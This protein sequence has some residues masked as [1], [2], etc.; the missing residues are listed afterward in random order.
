[1]PRVADI[2]ADSSSQNR[3][4]RASS[5]P[6]PMPIV[7]PVNV[8][9]I[10]WVN[11]VMLVGKVAQKP[12]LRKIPGN[13][14]LAEFTLDVIRKV[15]RKNGETT[16]EITKVSV[17]AWGAVAENAVKHLDKGRIIHVEGRLQYHEWTDT[18]TKKKRTKHDI[19]AQSVIYLDPP[20][21]SKTGEAS[22]AETSVISPD[23]LTIKKTEDTKDSSISPLV[24]PT[25]HEEEADLEA[26]WDRG[27]VEEI[28]DVDDVS[29]RSTNSAYRH[30]V[31]D[32]EEDED[33]IE[34]TFEDEWED[35]LEIPYRND[36]PLYRDE[37]NLDEWKDLTEEYDSII[38][39]QERT[40]L[41][42][43]EHDELEDRL[44]ELREQIEMMHD[45]NVVAQKL[46]ARKRD[47]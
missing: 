25:M 2:A 5:V 38:R 12:V 44:E 17:S 33:D 30:F 41:S 28:M 9:S 31:E 3:A 29:P 43:Q 47:R 45:V 6:L 13:Y 18:S 34:D 32:D 19:V 20:P 22:P 7:N 27:A 46:P 35:A 1:M 26:E 8:M 10:P 14:V 36:E 24:V 11:K 39:Q 23:K 4:F 21:I 15:R 37:I 42:Q 16:Q 40:D